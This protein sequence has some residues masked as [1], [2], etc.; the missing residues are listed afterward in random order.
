MFKKM[1]L[2]ALL[3]APITAQASDNSCV[4]CSYPDPSPRQSPER[5]NSPVERPATPVR[6]SDDSK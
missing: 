4:S 6:Q 3:V 1:S 5:S 2:L